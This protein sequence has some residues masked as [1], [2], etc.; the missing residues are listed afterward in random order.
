MKIDNDIDGHYG[1]A[2]LNLIFNS[3]I[4]FSLVAEFLFVF[5]RSD[6]EIDWVKIKHIR[7]QSISISI[8]F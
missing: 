4:A 5:Y 2:A 6:N 1:D 8:N 7:A 3:Y